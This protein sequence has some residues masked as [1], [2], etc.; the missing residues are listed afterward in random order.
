MPSSRVLSA[1][2]R[3]G[4][5]P[6]VSRAGVRSQVAARAATHESAMPTRA[7]GCHRRAIARS[8][9]ASACSP[10]NASS[11]L[12][13]IHHRPGAPVAGVTCGLACT[14]AA[15]A[16]ITARAIVS[17]SHTAMRSSAHRERASAIVMVVRTRA[18]P[19]AAVAAR[20]RWPSSRTMGNVS[21][22]CAP[23]A[24][25]DAAWNVLATLSACV[26]IACVPIACVSIACVSIACEPLPL[27]LP[28]PAD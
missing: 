4:V 16:R 17:S 12:A 26:P 20:T 3:A 1:V 21:Q 7:P 9:R 23:S 11:P 27:A 5:L 13:P 19:A 24:L 22:C 15:L 14:N 2:S 10:P 25:S 18:R 8:R 6:A 28:S